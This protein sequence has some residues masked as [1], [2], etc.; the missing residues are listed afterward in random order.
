MR[1]VLPP[2]DLLILYGVNLNGKAEQEIT[3]L[4]IFNGIY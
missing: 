3:N 2:F 4:L 1:S